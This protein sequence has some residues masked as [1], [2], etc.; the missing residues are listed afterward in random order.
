[1]SS[2]KTFFPIFKSHPNLTYLDNAATTHKPMHVL[3]SILDFYKSFNSN[4]HRGN[5][6]ISDKATEE[7]ENV[8][9][10]VADFIG[11]K[12]NE[13]IFTSG[14]TE[15]MNLA[16][17]L[18]FYNEIVRDNCTIA[19]PIE[20]HHSLVLPF[21]RF[22][23]N[24]IFY[25]HRNISEIKSEIAL[26]THVSNVTGTITD[27]K[28]IDAKIKVLDCAQS[29][30]HLRINVNKLGVDFLAFSAHKMYG[31]MGVGVL[32]VK[33]EILNRC[34]PVRLGGG[35]VDLV[36]RKSIRF[37]TFTNRF[38]PGTPNVAGVLGLGAAIDFLKRFD[39][40]KEL[41]K[42]WELKNYVIS[43][44]KKIDE[45]EIYTDE[46]SAIG[47]ISLYHK[48]IHPHDISHA[49]GKKGICVRAGNHCTQIFHR[50]IL[51]VPATFRISLAIYNNLDDIKKLIKEIKNISLNQF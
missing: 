11:A 17:E 41:E 45:I 33:E 30:P 14:T 12:P 23:E 38:E 1:M 5:Y 39:L 13:V 42:E 49:L 50:E 22:F 28:K 20:G 51:N 46:N 31:P 6:P 26:I 3:N 37:N 19:V 15:S 16:S 35:I 48:N 40:K 32:W 2:F 7:F 44:L 29:M 43:N 36:E 10:K 47:I 27:P 4:V 21:R 34:N 25:D 24:Q 8:R 9:K 18:I